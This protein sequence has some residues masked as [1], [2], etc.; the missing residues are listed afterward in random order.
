MLV[1]TRKDDETMHGTNE[2]LTKRSWGL[3]GIATV[4]MMWWCL[5]GDVHVVAVGDGNGF[6]SS[7]RSRMRQEM[8]AEMIVV[9]MAAVAAVVVV[10]LIVA[11]V[12]HSRRGLWWWWW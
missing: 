9:A 12:I 1:A 8:V 4:G 5:C 2:T 11:V 10:V 6:S 7:N 3:Y